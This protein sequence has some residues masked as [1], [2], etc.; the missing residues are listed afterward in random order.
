MASV[1]VLFLVIAAG[2]A[3]FLLVLLIGRSERA[4]SSEAPEPASI[5]APVRAP[6]GTA[7]DL[8]WVQARGVD[9]LE[10]LLV[11]VFAEMGFET[12]PAERTRDTVDFQAVDPAPIRGGR[13]HVHGVLG[14]GGPVEG[15]E[16]RAL[17]EAS[18]AGSVGKTVLVTLGRFSDDARNAARDEPVELVDGEGL[19]AL[20]KKHLPQV[21]A[22][23]TL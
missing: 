23:R 9:G 6:F 22:T 4:S 1:S 17:L 18:R 2:A 13:I 8:A 12:E 21:F 7:H 20:V 16:V 11:L 14:A 3:G 15:D 19:A 5:A 10:R